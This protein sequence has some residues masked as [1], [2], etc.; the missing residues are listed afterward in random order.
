MS[1]KQWLH[2]LLLAGWMALPASG[3]EI[4]KA[5]GASLRA[6]RVSDDQG[7]PLHAA[8]VMFRHLETAV[9]TSVLTDAE[10][11]F[12]VP[13]LANG[14][15]E[16][17]AQKKGVEARAP[18]TVMASGPWKDLVFT[19]PNL[20]VIP[21]SQ[22]STSDLVP[23]LP[24]APEKMLLVRTCGNCHSL[25][26]VLGGGGRSR[27]EWEEVLKRMQ[28]MQSGYIR[29]PPTTMP[30]ILEYLSRYF[31]P[32]SVRTEEMGRDIKR[33]RREEIPLGH[34][35]V[36]TE[37]DIPTAHGRPHT[38]VPDKRGNVWFTEFAARKIGKLD[39]LKGEITEYPLQVENTNPHGITVGPD[40]TVWFTALPTGIGRIDPATGKMEEF[41]VPDRPG[42]KFPGPHTIIVSRSGKIWFTQ[43]MSGTISNF[44][45][46]T[47]E[48]RVIEVEEGTTP[49]GILEKED[50]VFWFAVSRPGKI[51]MLNARTGEMQLYPVPTPNSVSQRFRFD[52]SGRLW[53]GE[54][55]G[56]KIGMFDPDTK[57]FTEYE[58]PFRSTPYSIHIDRQGFV[59][60]GCF[61]RD[62][63][64][65]FDP[66]TGQ[67]VE[68]PLPGVG[69]IIRDIWPDDQGRMWFVQWG[70]DKVTSAELVKRSAN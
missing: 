28:G 46:E 68:Y 21:I 26:T 2:V 23:H 63:L 48:F 9:T 24:E 15:Y 70:R 42:G 12:W 47:R 27:S 51:G 53:F 44:D 22:L 66:R 11:E 5:E 34:E 20:Q 60:V 6:G 4:T 30:S 8:T 3:F 56:D 32:D 69:A 25:G 37:Y 64:V 40:G 7:V 35:V 59:W 62:S 1:K 18:R 14:E 61:E 54:Y 41:K 17:S 65:R 43:I 55:G 13:L 45:P 38:A 10:G 31:G 33:N 52:T 67:M 58:L 50:D 16:I 57:R 36:F 29:V 19:L 39:I 49:Y